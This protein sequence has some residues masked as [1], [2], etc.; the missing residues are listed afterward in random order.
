[1]QNSAIKPA[2]GYPIKTERWDA[3]TLYYPH[4]GRLCKLPLRI[5][6]ARMLVI[7]D[8]WARLFYSLLHR[9]QPYPL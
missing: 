7:L 3:G 5:W 2:V 9:H 4:F 8:Q 6:H 1:L